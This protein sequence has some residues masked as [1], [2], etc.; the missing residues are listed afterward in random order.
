MRFPRGQGGTLCVPLAPKA[1]LVR[2]SSVAMGGDTL[3]FPGGAGEG[4]MRLP[5]GEGE[6]LSLPATA[7]MASL[8]RKRAAR[9]VWDGDARAS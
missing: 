4:N 3:R 1:G 7:K 5:G 6:P 2:T 8:R 9:V